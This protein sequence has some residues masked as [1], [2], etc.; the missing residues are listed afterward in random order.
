MRSVHFHDGIG[1]A[2]WIIVEPQDG[3]RIVA[4]FAINNE[5]IGIMAGRQR[6]G[7]IPNPVLGLHHVERK[8]FPLRKIRSEFDRF[9]EWRFQMEFGRFELNQ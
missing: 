5:A 3:T 7:R 4:P 6:H 2:E 8:F 1:P 9:G